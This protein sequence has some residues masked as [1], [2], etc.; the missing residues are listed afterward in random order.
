MF[1]KTLVVERGGAADFDDRFVCALGPRI[2][3]F[4]EQQFA[5][6]ELGLVDVMAGGVVGHQLVQGGERLFR[7]RIQLIGARQL[8]QHRIV[9]L[10]FRIRLQQRGIQMN[11]FRGAQALVGYQLALDAFGFRALE[12][13]I[14]ETAQGLG[15]QR[16]IARIQVEKALVAVHR[17]VGIDILRRIGADVHLLRV[18]ILDCRRVLVRGM[19]RQRHHERCKPRSVHSADPGAHGLHG[20]AFGLSL[21]AWSYIAANS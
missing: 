2:G 5:A 17:L 6:P 19:A 20:L 12:V 14:S 9:A 4:G 15:T 16:R 8:V 13:Q 10:I 11:R 3:F 1:V 21:A 7:L 18:E